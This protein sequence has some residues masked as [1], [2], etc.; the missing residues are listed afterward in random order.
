MRRFISKLNP[1]QKLHAHHKH[2]AVVRLADAIGTVTRITM[3][4]DTLC[5]ER[6]K[7]H[8]YSRL[9]QFNVVYW[10]HQY[11]AQLDTRLSALHEELQ[12]AQQQME[13]CRAGY[14]SARASH[15]MFQIL[16]DRKRAA[17]IAK[18][19]SITEDSA[20]DI[21]RYLMRRRQ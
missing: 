20:D 9:E 5:C 11:R 2:A 19:N 15:R 16:I 1:V 12:T 14:R 18:Q 8:D 13:A 17:H 10:A 7:S 4:I 3:Q 6:D 21:G